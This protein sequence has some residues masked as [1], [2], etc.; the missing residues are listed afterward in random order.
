M[1]FLYTV[2]PAHA[3]TFIKQ[4]S[5]LRMYLTVSHYIISFMSGDYLKGF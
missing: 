1:I 4:S 2:K 3:V 5:V